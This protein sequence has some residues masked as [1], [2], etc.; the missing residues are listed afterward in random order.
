MQSLPGCENIDSSRDAAV[1][2]RERVSAAIGSTDHR[3]PQKSARLQQ[4]VLHQLDLAPGDAL[5]LLGPP[6]CKAVYV[7][8]VPCTEPAGLVAVQH[9]VRVLAPARCLQRGI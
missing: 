3:K 5:E 2:T 7:A 9:A 1:F 4:D 6:A 8:D